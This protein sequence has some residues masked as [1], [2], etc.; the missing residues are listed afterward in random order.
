MGAD[1]STFLKLLGCCPQTPLFI[2][3]INMRCKCCDAVMTGFIK[4]RH[5]EEIDGFMIEEDM[6][7]QCIY[8]S[9]NSEYIDTHSYA[10]G[11][12]TENIVNLTD[13]E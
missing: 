1:V 5:I 3:R 8:I 7:N 6:C 12:I 13:Y 9:E 2:R 4:L 10:F 11:D